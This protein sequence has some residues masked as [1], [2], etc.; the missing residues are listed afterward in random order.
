MSELE[1]KIEAGTNL[2]LKNSTVHSR[3]FSPHGGSDGP[4]AQ[5]T[6][7]ICALHAR[8]SLKLPASPAGGAR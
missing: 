7:I 8:I 6:H 5:R 4:T 3:K 2:S 1:A